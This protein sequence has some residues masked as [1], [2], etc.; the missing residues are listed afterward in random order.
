MA[1][2][3]T[4]LSLLVCL[5]NVHSLNLPG[6]QVF[7]VTASPRPQLRIDEGRS[8]PFYY[9]NWMRRMDSPQ[10]A[11][12][13]T[14]TAKPKV[15]TPDLIFAEFE[16][17]N[18]DNYQKSLRNLL[19]KEKI[20]HKT[21]TTTAKPIYVADEDPEQ[22]PLEVKHEVPVINYVKPED[23]KKSTPDMTDYFALYNNLYNHDAA[24]VYMPIS[25]PR[26]TLPT[27]TTTTTVAPLSNVQDIWHVIDS[28]KYDQ[29]VGKW[30]EASID[31]E[32]EDKNPDSQQV[33][34][35]LQETDQD[36]NE[37]VMDDNFAL[38]G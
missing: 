25:T 9:H 32:N 23:A 3:I 38:P 10:N 18:G 31:S 28:E 36:K 7:V 20:Q 37:V 13:T 35:E 19:E 33:Q 14:T 24:P 17:G 21:T 5:C 4:Y 30:E 22:T 6:P 29:N 15:E 16:S 34:K 2:V 11:T 26:T 1:R 8:A 12:S 27:T